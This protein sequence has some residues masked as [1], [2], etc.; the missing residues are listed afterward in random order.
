MA[1]RFCRGAQPIFVAF[2]TGEFVLLIKARRGIDDRLLT[3]VR[4]HDT[5]PAAHLVL[6]DTCLGAAVGTGGG[7]RVPFHVEDG[8][9]HAFCLGDV[10]DEPTRL[11]LWCR[12]EIVEVIGAAC[13]AC[14]ACAAP[15]G[16]ERGVQ[17]IAA[18]GRF[19]E[20]EV[21]AVAACLGPVDAFLKPCGV[22][23]V[24]R[25]TGGALPFEI[26]GFC[27][28]KVGGDRRAD[29]DHRATIVRAATGSEQENQQDREGSAQVHVGVRFAIKARLLAGISLTLRLR[30]ADVSTSLIH[31]SSL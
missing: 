11:H 15:V 24:N 3:V 23:A 22:D 27:I 5:E 20:G 28:I 19:D 29:G 25:K 4:L 2:E 18:F 12:A 16:L 26:N 9:Q 7:K 14:L 30:P 8:G 21:Y 13:H 17:Q 1:R 6:H 10:S 31:W